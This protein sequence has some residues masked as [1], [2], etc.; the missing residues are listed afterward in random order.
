MIGKHDMPPRSFPGQRTGSGV[1]SQ[2][3]PPIAGD[4]ELLQGALLGLPRRRGAQRILAVVLS[5]VVGLLVM[6]LA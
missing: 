1:Y 2:A 3:L 5:L 4:E 6:A